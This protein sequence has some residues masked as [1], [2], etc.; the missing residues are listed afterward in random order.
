ML[1]IN[2]TTYAPHGARRG[3]AVS[4]VAGGAVLG[5]QARTRTQMRL[6]WLA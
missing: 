6:G 1:A 4:L 3:R 5:K 2:T